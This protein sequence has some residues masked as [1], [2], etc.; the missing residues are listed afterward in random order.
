MLANLF[1]LNFFTANS[2]EFHGN[3]MQNIKI[4]TNT[5]GFIDEIGRNRIFH[6]MNAVY[7]VAP[8]HPSLEGFDPL[9]SLSDIDANNLKQWGFNIVRLGVMW[10]GVEPLKGQYNSTYL[11][12]IETIVTN[13]A[14]NDIY[15]ILD[16]HQD[17]WHR[18]F[19]GEGVPDYVYDICVSEEPSSTPAFP[20]PAVNSTY[21]DDSD[22]YPSIDSCL[23]KGFFVYY[24]SAEVS[25]G[26]QC[27]Y[28]NKKG[29]WESFGGYW[30]TVAKRF[31]TFNNVL[32]YE[33][34]NEPWLGN[35]FE[36]PR[37]LLPGFTEKNYLQP[38]YNFL[39]DKIREVDNDKIIFWEGLTID[40]FP[41]GFTSSPGSVEYNDRQAL[42]YHIYC[43]MHDPNL[44]TELECDV[45]NT[46]F[47]DMR[48][49]YVIVIYCQNIYK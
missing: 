10:P 30:Q 5:H 12:N 32:G 28:D 35:A 16:F 38:M 42:A 36:D 2:L 39:H 24:L 19:C 25:A 8:W 48:L 46:E 34:I 11:D 6:G 21:P 7:K 22:G 44:K 29:L 43:P 47:L 15:V 26:F 27:L 33:L 49:K 41:N 37:R 9:N 13:L 23:S 4:D 18:E 40:Y 14:N 17:I 31:H 1:F 45:I 3:N 20:L